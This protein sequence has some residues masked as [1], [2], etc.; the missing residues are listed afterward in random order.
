MPRLSKPQ[1]RHPPAP[2]A[3][4]T[5]S[6]VVVIAASMFAMLVAA[7]LAFLAMT[8]LPKTFDT[9]PIFP[10]REVIFA[11]DMQRV[12]AA[13]LRRVA[14]GIRGSMLHTDLNDV[15]AAIKQVH[16]V[17]NADVRRRFPATLEV[18]VE[19]HRP[20]AKWMV[21]DAEVRALVNTFGEVFEADFDESLPIFSGPQGTSTE[22][23]AS[24]ASFKTQL[25]EIGQ[26]PSAVTLSARRAW[27]LKLDNGVLLELGRSEAVERLARF[28]KA[29]PVLPAIQ[30][31]N[32]RVDLRYQ[33]GMTVRVA[34][35]KPAASPTGATQKPTK[36]ITA[37]S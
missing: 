16:W 36:K 17:R 32:V 25:A 28:V 11:G 2:G 8:T 23:L 29:Y 26:V 4:F 27:Q 10:I 14:G 7:V 24:Y 19:E 37:K 1:P 6:R 20:F 22:V 30:V 3:H 15:K 12:D 35:A 5:R 9:S 34:D 18:S 21:G 31:A 13:E 33:S